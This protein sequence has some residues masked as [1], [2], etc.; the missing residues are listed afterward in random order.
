M[1]RQG[2]DIPDGHLQL[3]E[4]Y[5][6]PASDGGITVRSPRRS[7]VL[8]GRLVTEIFPRLLPLLD[9]T[10]TF[11]EVTDRLAG[12]V[13]GADA[14]TLKAALSRLIDMDVITVAPLT[15]R[16]GI[17]ERL[18]ERLTSQS[19]FLKQYGAD[20]STTH[21]IT[22][23]A[24]LLA[25]E[26]PLLPTIALGLSSSGVAHLTV[27]ARRPVTRDDVGQST[28]LRDSDIGEPMGEAVRRL[29]AQGD[30]PCEVS[31]ADFPGTKLAWQKLLGPHDV[32]AVALDAPVIS[33]PWIDDLNKAA[34][35]TSTPWTSGALLQRA[36][37]H[38]GPSVIPG[39]TACWKC[40]EYRFKSNLGVV[41]RYDE[42]E[43]HVADMV[44]YLD[45]GNIPTISAFT[46]SLVA[47]EA[48]RLL[49]IPDLFV[50]TAGSLLTI[51]LWEYR[52]SN[53]PVLKLPRCP[54]CSSVSLVPQERTWS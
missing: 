10:H 42:F 1:T 7:A 48:V 17:P 24:V 38:V 5:L 39:Q 18:R 43:A 20:D 13:E 34:L 12:V 53:H 3:A 11:T 16:N 25:G 23:A 52:L 9:G 30:M 40:F 47:L 35:A 19:R 27:A 29:L 15:H 26:G 28:Q 2:D 31:I 22:S 32:A 46:G 33:Q 6:V 49:G 14:A 36:T 21:R 44:E 41:A 54:H 8:R 4:V 37:V 51:D 50:R 45:H